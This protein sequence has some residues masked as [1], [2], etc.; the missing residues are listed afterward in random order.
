[1]N[2]SIGTEKINKAIK[3]QLVMNY[4]RGINFKLGDI[5]RDKNDSLAIKILFK[6]YY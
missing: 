5:F 6:L 2:G 4:F 3:D 1:M